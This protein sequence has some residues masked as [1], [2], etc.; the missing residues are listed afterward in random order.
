MLEA[1]KSPARPLSAPLPAEAE[2]I[3]IAAARVRHRKP[4]ISL[5]VA[6]NS[7]APNAQVDS[8]HTDADGW[9]SRIQDAFG[10][11]SLAFATEQLRLLMV[12]VQ[13]A[14]GTFDNTRLN[15]LMAVVD[16]AEPSNEIEAAV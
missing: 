14:D 10:T 11:R 2:A 9:V 3:D 8:P 4:R 12:T 5:K 7:K 16:G 15:A 13:G 6:P 1:K